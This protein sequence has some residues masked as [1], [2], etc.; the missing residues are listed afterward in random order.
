MWPGGLSCDDAGAL[1]LRSACGIGLDERPETGA[2]EPLDDLLDAFEG[3]STSGA[4]GVTPPTRA[5]C[6]DRGIAA[7]SSRGT[8]IPMGV[9]ESL[10]V[11]GALRGALSLRGEDAPARERGSAVKASQSSRAD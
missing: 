8:D 6:E 5:S 10:E 3:A 7:A 11:R 9:L 4:D 2:F 1:P